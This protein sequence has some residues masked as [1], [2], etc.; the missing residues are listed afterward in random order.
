M[1][2]AVKS[3]RRDR[4]GSESLK[5]QWKN[6][7]LLYYLLLTPNLTSQVGRYIKQIY[8]MI[9]RMYSFIFLTNSNNC[10]KINQIIIGII[11][12][13]TFMIYIIIITY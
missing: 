1:Q 5:R 4:N 3:N 11:V 9:D 2:V 7:V 10:H 6:A 13:H 8:L 12:H